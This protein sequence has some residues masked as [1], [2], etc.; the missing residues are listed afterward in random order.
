MSNNVDGKSGVTVYLDNDVVWLM[1][2]NSE[3]RP[4]SLEEMVKKA[5]R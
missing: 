2:K 4:V 3:Y 1:E 5:S